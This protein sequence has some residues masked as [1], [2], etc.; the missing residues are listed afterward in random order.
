[1]EKRPTIMYLY[2]A[3]ITRLAKK[4]FDNGYDKIKETR[5]G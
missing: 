5:V 4:V 1:M 3:E 2:K